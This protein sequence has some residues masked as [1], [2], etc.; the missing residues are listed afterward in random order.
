MTAGPAPFAARRLFRLSVGVFAI[1]GFVTSLVSLLVPR[2]TALYGSN[3][4]HALLVQMAFYLSYLLFAVPIGR[5]ITRHGYMR[6]AMIGLAIMSASTVLLLIANA[7]RLFPLLLLAL[8]LLSC[9]ITF[10]QIASNTVV[11]MVGAADGAAFRLNLLQ[12]CNSAGTIAAPLFGAAFL[13]EGVGAEG[14]P[15]FLFA[16]LILVVLTIS[17]ARNRR[18]LDTAPAA[19]VAVGRF[20]LLSAIRDR[21]L[22]WGMAAIFA[23][24]GAEVSIGAL[25]ANYLMQPGTLHARAAIAARMVSLYWA[26]AMVGRF[27]GS[28]LMRRV[29]PSTPLLIVA[30]CA[31]GLTAIAAGGGGLSGSVALIAV[32]LCNAI[33]YPTVYVLALP[34]QAERAT[35]AATLLCMA[36]VGGAVIPMLCGEIAD[37]A[38]LGPS[39][40]VPVLCYLVV[41]AFAV[42]CS[43]RNSERA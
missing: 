29:T 24:V 9:G 37:R 34:A 39:L 32:G 3:Y 23:Y 22:V 11:A 17:Y 27:A 36:V 35:S 41:A 10:L 31:A 4:S 5:I 21:K 19:E 42:S 14:G 26:G 2:L 6:S 15:P 12:G 28:I 25:L 1:G 38:G 16:L 18:L 20:D 43:G 30:L 40:F 8:L 33:M 13:T 7:M